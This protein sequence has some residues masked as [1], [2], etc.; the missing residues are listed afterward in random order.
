MERDGINDR[1]LILVALLHDLGK[2]MLLST[3]A[4]EHIV[5]YTAPIGEFPREAG[6]D[7]I[8][9]QF[10]HDEMVYSRLRDYVPD[11]IAW[12]VRYHS[13]RTGAIEPYMNQRDRTYYDRYLSRFQPYDQGSKSHAHLPRVDMAKYRALIEEVFPQPILL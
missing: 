6:L 7:N 2:V 4:P 13:A 12:T 5:G 3:E 11:H 10:G 8:V 1:D 9:F